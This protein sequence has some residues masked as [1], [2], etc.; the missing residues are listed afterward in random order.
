MSSKDFMKCLDF[1]GH[2]CPGLAV[3][4][5]PA[6]K[7]LDRPTENCTEHLLVSTFSDNVA[8]G[9]NSGL[10][11]RTEVAPCVKNVFGI[12]S[13]YLPLDQVPN[14]WGLKVDEYL[15]RANVE[16][17]WACIGMLKYGDFLNFV[18]IA[19]LA[20][21]TIFCFLSIVPILLRNGDRTYAILAVAEAIILS[22]AASGILG[23]GGALASGSPY[24]DALTLFTGKGNLRRLPNTRI[25]RNLP[26]DRPAAASP[27]FGRLLSEKEACVG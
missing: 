1:R 4:R 27:R 12:L 2:I 16:A 24:V 17:G 15:H 21:V 3:G 13:P 23:G 6:E 22:V 7:A 26:D 25:W 18:G 10:A 11:F 20:A 19:I 5:R 14:Y 8:H 9:A